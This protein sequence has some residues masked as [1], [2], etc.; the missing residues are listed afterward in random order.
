MFSENLEKKNF[1]I[2]SLV[3]KTDQ[4][5]WGKWNHFLELGKLGIFDVMFEILGKFYV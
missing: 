1:A 3:R 5:D 2:L 4:N